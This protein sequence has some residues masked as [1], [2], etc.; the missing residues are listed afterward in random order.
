MYS[1]SYKNVWVSSHRGFADAIMMLL[2]ILTDEFVLLVKLTT[3]RAVL[4][5]ESAPA[6]LILLVVGVSTVGTARL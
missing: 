1:N 6:C 4:T 2:T 5:K 3:R